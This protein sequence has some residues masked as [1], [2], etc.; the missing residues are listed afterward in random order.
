MARTAAYSS[1]NVTATLDGVQVIGLWDGDDAILVTPGVERG[2]GLVGADG[3]SIFSISPDQSATI[4]VKLQQ[5]SATNRQLEQKL[6]AQEAGALV[7]SFP[8]DVIDRGNG[9][10]GSTDQCFI[11]AA[12]TFSRG[13]AAVMVEWILW[14]GSWERK[15]PNP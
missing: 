6:K 1:K 14:T 5:T 11:Q 2:V 12:P 3:S 15:I 8:F 9:G 7:T 13:K 10:G 4:S